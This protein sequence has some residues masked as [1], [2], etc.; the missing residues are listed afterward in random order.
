MDQRFISGKGTH[1]VAA[2]K[3]QH[4]NDIRTTINIIFLKLKAARHTQQLIQ[5]NISACIILP[6]WYCSRCINI[7]LSLLNQNAHQRMRDTFRHGPGILQIGGTGTS[8]IA[9]Q[10]QLT[11]TDDLQRVSHPLGLV[12]LENFVTVLP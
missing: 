11:L 4:R 5:G 9:I 3:L 2:I 1:I 6:F 10:D 7:Q 8:I 12:Q